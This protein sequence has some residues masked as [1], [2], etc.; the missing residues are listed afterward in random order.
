MRKKN[1]QE[2]QENVDIKLSYFSKLVSLGKNGNTITISNENIVLAN[3]KDKALGVIII[4]LKHNLLKQHNNKRTITIT[5]IE[6]IIEKQKRLEYIISKNE[7]VR[8]KSNNI[9]LKHIA[10]WKS[11]EKTDIDIDISLSTQIE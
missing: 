10:K 2:C 7:S 4:L 11:F 3:T 8:K 5:E 1:K 6:N 9:N